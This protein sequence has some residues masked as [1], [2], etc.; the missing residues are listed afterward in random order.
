M[1]IVNI[2]CRYYVCAC[3]V[4]EDIMAELEENLGQIEEVTRFISIKNS[5][6]LVNLYFL[7][8][9]KKIH[10]RQLANNR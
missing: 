5:P 7:P 6:A 4:V 3:V 8:N 2:V 9:L 1:L 10:G